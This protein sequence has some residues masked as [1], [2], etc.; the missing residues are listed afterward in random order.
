MAKYKTKLVK[1]LS[2]E[3][4]DLVEIEA[5]NFVDKTI[6]EVD[7]THR[8]HNLYDSYGY[9]V[10]LDGKLLRSS[11]T[12]TAKPKEAA[13]P[14]KWYQD[15]LFGYDLMKKT[16]SESGYNPSV[17]KGYVVVIA[18]TMPYATVLEE[19]TSHGLSRDYR[20]IAFMDEEAKKFGKNIAPNLVSEV[21]DG[22]Y[23]AW[24]HI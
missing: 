2:N 3:F 6:S 1:Q 24:R 7:Y 9:G 16:F 18:A 20:V 12:N 14:R 13:E 10:Y 23:E 15:E 22:H 21:K 5:R 4:L 8:T 11:V 19:G 17:S